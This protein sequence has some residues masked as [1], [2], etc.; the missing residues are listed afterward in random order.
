MRFKSSI[1]GL[2]L[3]CLTSPTFPKDTSKFCAFTTSN[4]STWVEVKN[5]I[6]TAIKEGIVRAGDIATVCG[7]SKSG[8][9]GEVKVIFGLSGPQGISP[10]ISLH[11]Q[12][13]T[14]NRNEND[15]RN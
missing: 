13:P 3:L 7:M 14:G 10:T 15:I 6:E 1:V 4:P 11:Y 2:I 8:K 5:S 9:H 12:P